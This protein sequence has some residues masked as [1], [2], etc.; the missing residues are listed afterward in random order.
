[1]LVHR[2]RR[3]P[4]IKSTLGQSLVSQSTAILEALQIPIYQDIALLYNLIKNKQAM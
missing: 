4:N 1:M 2:V 3:L